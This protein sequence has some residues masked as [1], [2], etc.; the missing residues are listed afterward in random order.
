MTREHMAPR[1]P[2]ATYR[3][4]LRNGLTLD[5]VVDEAW[6]DLLDRLGVSHLYLS[7][8]FT[9]A[10]GSTHGYDVVDHDSVDP[11]LGG[12]EA[13]GRLAAAAHG[14]N[15]GI[16]VDVVPNHVAADPLGNRR[17]WDVLRNGRSSRWADLFDIDW[18][19]SESRLA[20]R[21]LLPVLADHCGREVESGAFTARIGDD[22]EPS[23][24][25]PAIDVPLDLAS[26]AP[27]VIEVSR[28]TPLPSGLAD[29]IAGLGSHD[30]LE[31]ME[32]EREFRA[33]L[34]RTIVDDPA[35]AGAF[36]RVL[37]GVVTDPDR[38]DALLEAQPYR[39]ARWQAGLAD[40]GYRRFFDNSTLVALRTDRAETFE[41]T[42][43]GLR[44]WVEAGWIDGVRVDHIDGLAD[45]DRYLEQLRDLVGPDRWI[46]VE[47]I[48]AAEETIPDR[49]PVDGTTGYEV[50]E[51]IDRLD[52]DTVGRSVLDGLARRGGA[53]TDVERVEL[54][55]TELVLDELLVPDVNRLVDLAVT[56][57][58]R[59]RR[60][61]DTTRRE[62]RDLVVAAL[63]R[64][65][66]YRTYVRADEV[67]TDADAAVIDRCLT[68][69][70][71]EVPG[72][73]RDLVDL[74]R[75][76]LRGMGRDEVDIEFRTRFQQLSGPARA[77]GCEDTA[78][79]RLVSLVSR[80]DVGTDPDRW[81][82][83]LEDFH[84]ALSSRQA[85]S[86]SAMS[87][88]STHDSKR[89]ADVRATIGVL[90]QWSAELVA[91]VEELWQGAGRGPAP[92][93]DSVIVQTLLG[94]G[95]LDDERLE[96][97]LT[98]AMREGKLYSSWL[99]PD[100]A[101]EQ[102]V[103]ERARSIA[104][105]PG[106][107]KSLDQLIAAIGPAA[108]TAILSHTL[109]HLTAPGVP[110]LYQGSETWHHRLVDPDNRGRVDPT[111]SLGALGTIGDGD[112]PLL[113]G[114]GHDLA[115]LALTRLA[116]AVRASHQVAFDPGTYEVL[117]AR[118]PRSD[119]CVAFVRGGEVAVVVPRL[120]R[121]R[122]DGWAGSTIDLP[123][124][125]W[126]DRCNGG[127]WSGTV[128]LDDLL[129]PWPLALLERT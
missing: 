102:A 28:D 42:H 107:R 2:R 67:P 112:G 68:R 24:H 124:G 47:K 91:L 44:R 29:A 26:L 5:G 98:K 46:V 23:L 4:Q 101:T 45:P 73:D 71:H 10:R 34:Q 19:T 82:I 111:R 97:F 65:D 51:L 13:L 103:L 31:R 17:W 18:E 38:L 21:L 49:W 105:D 32:L 83:D 110:D 127:R 20:G 57:C 123:A 30:R 7:P 60:F 93:L 43:G 12:E 115:K 33:A 54:T 8:V 89:S 59:R 116:L 129:R 64:F 109:V 117:W 62:V 25:H 48:V 86:P 119:H 78:G 36:A 50:A 27:L 76:V 9:A 121:N 84:V 70:I 69:V 40:L 63:A 6:L 92:A 16:V 79:Y 22:G 66:R 61:R 75:T 94:V 106:S 88:A 52:V 72:I 77:K 41:L 108:R 99:D 122:G 58:E 114:P 55:S 125:E 3:L 100:V 11:V 81:G 104:S 95:D 35:V 96:G 53:D 56:M 74:V 87:A 118:G 113:V 128:D 37:D 120:V 14:R 90:S 15:I 85:T 1:V 80:N 39:L 126:V